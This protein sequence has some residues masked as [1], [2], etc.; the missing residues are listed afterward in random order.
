M[1]RIEN[2]EMTEPEAVALGPMADQSPNAQIEITNGE[3]LM[4]DS[5]PPEGSATILSS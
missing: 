1:S 2:L 5:W 3:W 4:Q